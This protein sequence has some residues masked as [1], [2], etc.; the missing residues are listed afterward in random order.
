MSVCIPTRRCPA[1]QR[2][3]DVAA[4]AMQS[5][6]DAKVQQARPTAALLCGAIVVAATCGPVAKVWLLEAT[7]S[8]LAAQPSTPTQSSQYGNKPQ[9][10]APGTDPV[11]AVCT[12]SDWDRAA[13]FRP[14]A[15]FKRLP[16]REVDGSLVLASARCGPSRP[17]ECSP[18]RLLPSVVVNPNS[19]TH[20]PPSVRRCAFA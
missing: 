10:R 8:R 9:K 17:S 3:Y 6:H 7:V 18:A 5:H 16:I 20:A 14:L 2:W 12:Q 4:M 13:E 19:R 1:A 11:L 15:E